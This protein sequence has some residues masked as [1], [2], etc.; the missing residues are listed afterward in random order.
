MPSGLT[1]S[2]GETE[3]S[4]SFTATQDTDDDDDESVLLAFGTLPT[5][6]SAGANSEATVNITDDDVPSVTVSYEQSSYTV[7]ENSSVT[8]KVI[9]SADPE[10]DGDGP[11]H[12]E[13][14]RAARPTPTTRAC[15]AASPSAAAKPRSPSPSRQPRTRTTTTTKVSVKLAF[16]TLPT[17]VSAG[18][19]SEATVNITD[20]DVPVGDG[21]L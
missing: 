1:F 5:G 20:D 17:G 4:F 13:P 2:S 16:G 19:N 7:G 9:L 18:A 15:R 21:Q 8:V 10:R 11:D 3:K 6:V 12:Q 14:T